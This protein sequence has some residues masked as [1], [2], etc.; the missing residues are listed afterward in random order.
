[1]GR[2]HAKI[3]S[4]DAFMKS[5]VEAEF[6]MRKNL[7]AQVEEAIKTETNPA[8]IAGMKKAVEIIF[9]KVES[10]DVG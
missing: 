4:R 10:N 3:I 5:F 7:A 6:I 9:G 2:K 8:T 1:M